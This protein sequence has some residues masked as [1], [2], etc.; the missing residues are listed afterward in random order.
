MVDKNIF[1]HINNKFV[2]YNNIYMDNHLHYK[3]LVLSKNFLFL[4]L[5]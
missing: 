4:N 2:N 3:I 5:F 1:Q